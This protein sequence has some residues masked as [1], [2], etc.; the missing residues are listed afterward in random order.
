MY[1]WFKVQGSRAF[2]MSLWSIIRPGRV[3]VNFGRGD[4]W[5]HSPQRP[6]L[7]RL[8]A[9]LVW[10]ITMI[11]AAL[12]VMLSMVMLALVAA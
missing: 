6:L 1:H 12:L 5:H 9:A 4:G 3:A 2:S 11:G 10:S 7:L 8:S